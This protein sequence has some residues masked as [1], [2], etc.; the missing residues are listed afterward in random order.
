M[1][2]IG[3]KPGRGKKNV[4]VIMDFEKNADYFL[5]EGS[6][7]NLNRNEPRRRHTDQ[8]QERPD[9]G[10]AGT[11]ADEY[12]FTKLSNKEYYIDIFSDIRAKNNYF[13]RHSDRTRMM[14][15]STHA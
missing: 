15:I 4:D 14:H 6:I 1:F 5:F 12:E 9:C 7:N 10:T 2:V 13:H 8:P 11:I 3:I